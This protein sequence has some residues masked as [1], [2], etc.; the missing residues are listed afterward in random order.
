MANGVVAT[1]GVHVVAEDALAGACQTVGVDEAAD[2]GVIVTGLQVIKL[3]FASNTLATECKAM[4]MTIG[5][6]IL[7]LRHSYPTSV[8]AYAVPPSPKGEG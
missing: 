4:C 2:G 3:G 8:T 1:V 7:S 6:A 5:Y